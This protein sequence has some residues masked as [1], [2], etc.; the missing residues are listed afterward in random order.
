LAPRLL[1]GT[2]GRERQHACYEENGCLLH[3]CFLVQRKSLGALGHRP[4]KNRK[5]KPSVAFNVW[6]SRFLPNILA[7]KCYSDF[8]RR[9][10]RDL[11]FCSLGKARIDERPEILRR[12]GLAP[13]CGSHHRH[14]HGAIPFWLAQCCKHLLQSV[15]VFRKVRE[16]TGFFIR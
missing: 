2:P 10:D 6:L 12:L 15:K 16:S 11:D 5:G 9:I 7:L 4:S 1:A 8:V 14:A 13:F 3:P